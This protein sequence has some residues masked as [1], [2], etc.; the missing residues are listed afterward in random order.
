MSRGLRPEERLAAAAEIGDAAT[1]QRLIASGVDVNWLDED[2][3]SALLIACRN[4]SRES[5]PLLLD[6]NA[7]PDIT[8]VKYRTTPLVESCQNSDTKSALLLLQRGANPNMPGGRW[9]AHK[10]IEI[11]AHK[12]NH[13]LFDALLAAGATLPSLHFV[14]TLLTSTIK[15]AA[16][17][18]GMYVKLM[19]LL[20]V[21]LSISRKAALDSGNKT[22]R[23]AAAMLEALLLEK[24]AYRYSTNRASVDTNM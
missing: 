20:K 8:D 15:S 13:V 6:A 21:D 14:E 10:P 5:I 19:E 9:P 7:D 18:A 3:D 22:G 4:N 23:I 2:G 16:E 1:V 17:K 12:C 11:A 24:H